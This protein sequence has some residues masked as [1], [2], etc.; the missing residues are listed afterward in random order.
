MSSPEI[1]YQH[2]M[3]TQELVDTRTQKQKRYDKE[4]EKRN[5]P[6][7]IEMFRVDEIYQF[8]VT[9]KPRWRLEKSLPLFLEQEDPRT[10]EERERDQ[11]QAAERLTVPLFPRGENES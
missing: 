6:K 2:D 1:Y 9:G 10:G 8:G 5:A 3:F 7:Q 11:Q 4:L